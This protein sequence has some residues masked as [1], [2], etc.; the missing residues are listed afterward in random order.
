MDFRT[1]LKR[2]LDQYSEDGL[3]RY[4]VPPMTQEGEDLAA[5]VDTWL[6]EQT[7][8]PIAVLG[9]YGQGKTTFARHLAFNYAKRA[10]EDASQRLPI[11]VRLGDIANE[12][13]LEG[14]LGKLFTATNYVKNYNFSTFLELNK[15]GRFIVIF[16]GFDEMK[17]TLSWNDFRYNLRQINRLVCQRGKVIILG[18]PTAFLTDAEH[19][20]ALHGIKTSVSVKSGVSY[21]IRDPE[22]PNYREINIAAFTKS[23]IEVFLREYLKYLIDTKEVESDKAKLRK[24]LN[25]DV[26]QLVDGRIG[27]IAKR[28][29]QLKMIT[30][31]LPDFHGKLAELTVHTLYDYFITF[32]IEREGDKLARLRYTNQQRRSFA[33]DIAFWLWRT[34]ERSVSE[35]AIPEA[36]LGQYCEHGEDLESVTRDLVSG[37][38]LDRRKGGRLFF[39]HRSFQEFLVAEA[40]H[41][42]V[43]Q[44]TL[45]VPDIPP[46]LTPQVEEFLEGFIDK[47]FLTAV[48]VQ[49]DGF[50]GGLP[51]NFLKLICSYPFYRETIARD[52]PWAL[53]LTAL[54]VCSESETEQYFASRAKEVL[55][56]TR[57]TK[58]AMLVLFAALVASR[59]WHLLK[60]G[61][62]MIGDVFD[63]FCRI[64]EAE[65]SINKKKSKT[66]VRYSTVTLV[67]VIKS[68]KFARGASDDAVIISG[69]YRYIRQ[70]LQSY[71]YISNWDDG[72]NLR[73]LDAELPDRIIEW[74]NGVRAEFQEF[75]SNFDRETTGVQSIPVR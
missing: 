74:R 36:L 32:V 4:Y 72:N 39:P 53:L 18:R 15:F 33:R 40:I 37:S 42:G 60:H 50:R 75:L 44:K 12:Q 57:D 29:V 52:S 31:L 66:K 41:E 28:P 1:Y 22:W 67:D 14:L 8:E 43:I 23:Q 47:K 19:N 61:S 2:L 34:R 56:T 5:I 7:S 59:K 73:Y 25:Y 24:F 64:V 16:D 10:L 27:D 3:N 11:L 35:D 63:G 48:A 21:E 51:L 46:V 58:T 17:Q 55:K 30:E 69:V 65:R 62:R 13:S 68:L 6:A 54:A 71:C 49:L 70:E 9:S 20:Y 45:S 38:L 26:Q